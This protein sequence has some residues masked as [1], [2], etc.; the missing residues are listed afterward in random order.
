MEQIQAVALQFLEKEGPE[1]ISMRRIARKVGITPMAIYHHFPN[2]DALLVAVTEGEFERLASCFR[3]AKDA[4]GDSLMNAISGYLDYA[5][6]R[7]QVFDFVFGQKRKGARQFPA[8]FRARKSPTL[9]ILADE[10]N[11][12]MQAGELRRDDMWETSLAIWA[13]IHG[14]V[15]LHRG[16]RIDL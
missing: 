10:V 5:L 6:S 15:V 4:S 9:T 3:L 8:D 16:G 2:R 14:L 12:R 11:A 1:G 7:P 13:L